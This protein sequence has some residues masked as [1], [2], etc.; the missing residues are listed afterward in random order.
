MSLLDLV[1]IGVGGTIGS[2]LF[3]LTGLVAHS[4]AGPSASVSWLISGL[5]AIMSGCCY[6]ELSSRIPIA[7]ST[8]A[9]A[10]VSMGELPAVLAAACLSVEYLAASAAGT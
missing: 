10:Y 3:V 1:A 6:A 8:Y 4:Y 2:G 7:G 5:T 9:Y